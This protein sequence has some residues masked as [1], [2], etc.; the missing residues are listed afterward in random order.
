MIRTIDQKDTRRR[1]PQRLGGPE[2]AKASPHDDD[3]GTAIIHGFPDLS[4]PSAE[5][6]PCAER[7]EAQFAAN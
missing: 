6:N 5:S 7:R 4:H 2:T 3:T 1:L